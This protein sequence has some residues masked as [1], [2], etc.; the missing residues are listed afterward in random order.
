MRPPCIK[1]LTVIIF[2]YRNETSYL[3]CFTRKSTT[4]KKSYEV[5]ISRSS[6]QVK[7]K[8]ILKRKNMRGCRT[9]WGE[10]G[11]TSAWWDKFLN[12]KVMN[13]DWLENFRMSKT[14]FEKLVNI[15]R[16]HLEKQVTQVRKTNINRESN[17]YFLV[18]H[19]WRSPLS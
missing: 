5:E 2:L 14:S 3:N 18:L 9:C 19:Q 10:K 12:N 6:F 8:I 15:M 1:G 4:F 7:R 16:P 13:F 17:C 11:W